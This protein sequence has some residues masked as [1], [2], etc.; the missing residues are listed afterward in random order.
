MPIFSRFHGLFLLLPST[1]CR[2]ALSASILRR[3]I[4]QTRTHSRPSESFCMLAGREDSIL[5][6]MGSVA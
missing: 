2:V 3:Q 6:N 1:I 4:G 5:L